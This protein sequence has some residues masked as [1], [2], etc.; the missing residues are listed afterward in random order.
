MLSDQTK[1][2]VSMLMAIAGVIT[3]IPGPID[4]TNP[5]FLAGL[6]LAAVPAYVNPSLFFT[7]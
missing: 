7:K 1:R 5:Q 2:I 4:F 3:A 6:V